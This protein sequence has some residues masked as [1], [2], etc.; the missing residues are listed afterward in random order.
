M[1]E[2][3]M[4]ALP[5]VTIGLFLAIFFAR[6]AVKKKKEEAADDFGLIGMCIGMSIGV[7]NILHWECPWEC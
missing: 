1:R 2:F 5:W 6:S 4:A 3:I 7:G